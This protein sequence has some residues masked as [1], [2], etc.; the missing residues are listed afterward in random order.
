MPGRD[1]VEGNAFR[2]LRREATGSERQKGPSLSRESAVERLRQHCASLSD[3][4]SGIIAEHGF[5]TR[6]RLVC[7]DELKYYRSEI[8]LALSQ[9]LALVQSNA[10]LS[11]ELREQVAVCLGNI[12]CDHMWADERATAEEL[13][14]EA[15]DL[16]QG[17]W[18]AIS[19]QKKFL[20]IRYAIEGP[21]WED[22]PLELSAKKRIYRRF[23]I[24][25]AIAAMLLV[26]LVADHSP[27]RTVAARP[28][29]TSGPLTAKISDASPAP[30]ELPIDFQLET[31]EVRIDIEKEH[32]AILEKQMA[33]LHFEV[34]SLKEHRATGAPV[35]SA[36]LNAELYKYASLHRE[37]RAVWAEINTD[38]HQHDQLVAQ[39]R[40]LPK[41]PS[42]DGGN[43]H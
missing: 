35:D 38:I 21:W 6:N 14:L 23:G 16:A 25:A 32:A 30:V 28:L 34:E 42:G 22:S 40:L 1:R 11:F 36:R 5:V 20:Q 39:H 31:L 9:A 12:A 26:F 41:R 4:A 24:S 2:I 43:A 37:S 17:T 18:A 8:E 19:L 10:A 13:I 33:A 27:S 7:G 15:V 29:Q 3:L